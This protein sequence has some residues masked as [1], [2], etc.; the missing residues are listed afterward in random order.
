MYNT[1]QKLNFI[2]HITFKLIKTTFLLIKLETFRLLH[3]KALECPVEEKLWKKFKALLNKIAHGG[4]NTPM[5]D[6]I[7]LDA[8]LCSVAQIMFYSSKNVKNGHIF[9]TNNAI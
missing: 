4:K 6:E 1:A 2:F 8:P 9:L 7:S 5:C 3:F